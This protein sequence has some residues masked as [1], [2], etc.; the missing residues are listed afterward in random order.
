MCEDLNFLPRFTI[1]DQRSILQNIVFKAQRLL[2]DLF[3]N[4]R[5]LAF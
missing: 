4:V 5:I 3:V 1:C 2:F